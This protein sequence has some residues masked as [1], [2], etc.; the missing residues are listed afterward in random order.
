MCSATLIDVLGCGILFLA[1]LVR[2]NQLR[3]QFKH[4]YLT[5]IALKFGVGERKTDGEIEYISPSPQSFFGG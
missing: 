3:R 4:F 5:L 2:P 1:S